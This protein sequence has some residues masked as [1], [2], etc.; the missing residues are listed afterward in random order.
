MANFVFMTRVNPSYDDI[1]EIRYHFPKRYLRVAQAA[2][3]NWILY[4]EPRSPGE[5]AEVRRGRMAYFATAKVSRV[6]PD[7]TRRDHFYAFIEH[8][9]EF[10]NPVSLRT[11]DSFPESTLRRSDGLPKKGLMGWAMRELPESDYDAIVKAGLSSAPLVSDAELPD[12]VQETRAEPLRKV[13]V[14]RPLR[15]AAFTRVVA[16]AYSGK[17]AFTSLHLV[18]GGG[19]REIEAAHI[20]PV[21]DLGPDSVRNGVAASRTIHWLFDHHLLSLED[22]GKLLFDP[23][24]IPTQIA[25]LLN[26]DGYAHLPD[27]SALRPHPVFLRYHRSHYT[28]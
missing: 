13:L 23:K 5:D 3:G 20:R 27:D 17:C 22:D 2:V 9:L 8:Y 15:D 12:R 4:Y 7:P 28:G 16:R 6:E 25:G 26:R 1:P 19:S 18:N 24:R 21:E 14:E 10:P 11:G